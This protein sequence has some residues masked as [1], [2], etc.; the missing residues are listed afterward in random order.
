[1]MFCPDCGEVLDDVDLADPCRCCGGNRRSANVP[2]LCAV[3]SSTAP[4]PT[5]VSHSYP[6]DVGEQIDVGG[7]WYRSSSTA[8]SGGGRQVFDGEPPLHEQDVQQVCDTLRGALAQVGEH[9]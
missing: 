3:G 9:W 5:V 6:G 1:M 4:Q 7:P 2:A 8:D